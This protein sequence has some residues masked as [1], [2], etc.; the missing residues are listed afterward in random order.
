[1]TPTFLLLFAITNEKTEID[2][3]RWIPAASRQRFPED[4]RSENSGRYTLLM[5]HIP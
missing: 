5:S 4:T 3:N 1:M 2:A